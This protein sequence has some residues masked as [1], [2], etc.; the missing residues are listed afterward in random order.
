MT[1]VSRESV[2]ALAGPTT[3]AVTAP[4]PT[5]ENE[6]G[7]QGV[8]AVAADATAQYK[9]FCVEEGCRPNS[10]LLRFLEERGGPVDLVALPLQNNY[11]GPRGLRPVVRLID[12]CQ[13]LVRVNLDGNGVDNDAL[14]TLCEVCERHISLTTLSLRGNP[15]TLP[16]GKRLLQLLLANPRIT[17]IDVAETELFDT[18]QDAITA[19]AEA[20]RSRA[21]QG[22]EPHLTVTVEGQS[23]T[24]PLT[25]SVLQ[26]PSSKVRPVATVERLPAIV[27]APRT[28]VAADSADGRPSDDGTAAYRSPSGKGASGE[29]CITKPQPRPPVPALASKQSPRMSPAQLRKLREKFAERARVYAEINRSETSRM[30]YEARAKL[31]A[32]E[33]GSISVGKDT[34]T[35]G[36]VS[37]RSTPLPPTHRTD[38]SSSDGGGGAKEEAGICTATHDSGNA[39]PTGSQV[40]PPMEAATT[41]SAQSEADQRKV[42]P[43]PPR[44]SPHDTA[45]PL[46]A[47]AVGEDG[48]GGGGD[49]QSSASP[50]PRPEVMEVNVTDEQRSITDVLEQIR[51]CKLSNTERFQLLFDQGCREYAHKNM[52]AAYLAWSEAMGIA[53]TTKNREWM[54]VLG[55]NLKRLSYEILVQEGVDHLDAGRLEDADR[56]FELAGEVATTAHNAA[57]EAEMQKARRNVQNA[58]FHRCHEAALQLFEKAQQLPHQ[59]VTEDDHFVLPG[60]ELLVRHS[61]AFVNEWA[62]ML[63]VQEAV[64]GWS[65]AA[66]VAT[67]LG[68]GAMGVLKDIIEESLTAVS[69]FLAKRLFD[70]EE[71][72]GV[73]WLRTARYQYEECVMLSELWIDIIAYNYQHLKHTLLGTIAA[74]QLGNLYL[75]TYQLSLAQEQFDIAVRGATELHDTL[76][77]A[78]GLTF[79]A[80]LCV[81]RAN[82]ALAEHQ[83]REGI[84]KW[85]FLRSGVHAVGTTAEDGGGDGSGMMEK[86]VSQTDTSVAGASSA[87]STI[88]PAS[89]EAVSCSSPLLRAIPADFVGV[90]LNASYKLLVSVMA[91]TYRYREALE[92]LEGGL[93]QQYEDLLLQKTT[94][95]FTSAPSLDQIAAIASEIRTSLV[96]YF[97]NKRYDWAVV[98]NEY[99][100]SETVMMWVVAANRE[101]RYVELNV[102]KDYRTTVTRL[103]RTVR[104]SLHLDPLQSTEPAPEILTTLPRHTWTEP[105]QTLYAILIDP[106]LDFIRAVNPAAD[107]EG[108]PGVLTIIPVGE[109]WTVPYNALITKSGAYVVEHVALQLAFSATQCMFAALSASRVR[110]RD[111]HRDVV[112]VQPETDPSAGL[113][114]QCVFPFDAARSVAEGEAV[115][116]TLRELKEQAVAEAAKSHPN[117]V[118][119]ARSEVL[120]QDIDALRCMLPLARSVHIA[121]ATTLS[122]LEGEHTAGAVCAPMLHDD[123][124]LLRGNE[125]AQMELFAELVV[126]SNTNL[127][128]SRVCGVHDDVLGLVRSFLSGGA[129]C[130]VVGQWCTPD[131]KPVE[132][133]TTFYSVHW[134][135][136]SSLDV[137]G[138]SSTVTSV[139]TD[140]VTLHRTSSGAEPIA[141]SQATEKAALVEG[142]HK[143]V[144]LAQAMRLLLTNDDMRYNPRAWAGY[145]CVGNGF[146]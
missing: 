58:V 26:P 132:L 133:F 54:A 35:E 129:P 70:V 73:S 39:T 93:V 78:M 28:T 55:S 23:T 63:L 4:V 140:R 76:L 43:T 83:L 74:M 117:A 49:G 72:N 12:L 75:A 139:S 120:V 88:T 115:L 145:Y 126:L 110:Q 16:G 13:T 27:A 80:V 125:I 146:F 66:R 94:A 95:N 136:Q 19:A 100:V 98:R 57:W 31:A 14:A 101:M 25:R 71:P 104:Q 107:G 119:T 22:G 124:G 77:E 103:L 135:R 86:A 53:A 141:A 18:V 92:T 48:G 65:E 113:L 90:M 11:L 47:N 51:S 123:V 85:S 108:G 109:L 118:P 116:A 3:E 69:C 144:S 102:S 122:S 82:H 128:T 138:R 42:S 24:S 6:E 29:V 34:T 15:I 67:R 40:L 142:R 45:L 114:F 37:S 44:R 41:S 91:S 59:T 106:V 9:Q 52:D 130:V 5:Y 111:L 60:T 33:R 32:L 36:S 61:E 96:Y 137:R 87:P 131:M 97:L 17:S 64:R 30:A 10:A 134:G 62:H 81:Q 8:D 84:L 46:S 2:T 50:P 143:A 127:S 38:H 56:C 68:V 1:Q 105:L 79:S 99:E 7:G 121:S 21:A 20:N 112:V 89:S